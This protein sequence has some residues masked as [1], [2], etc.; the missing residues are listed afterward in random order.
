ME[1]LVERFRTFIHQHW[2]APLNYHTCIPRETR[3]LVRDLLRE[4]IRQA[5][6]ISGN[7]PSGRP[8]NLFLKTYVEQNPVYKEL[9]KNNV[10]LL[11]GAQAIREF[12]DI[13]TLGRFLL[14]VVYRI[15]TGG[16]GKNE[17]IMDKYDQTASKEVVDAQMD[18]FCY[19][20]MWHMGSLSVFYKNKSLVFG[21]PMYWWRKEQN[22]NTVSTELEN[23]FQRYDPKN[24][25]NGAK[26]FVK[27]MVDT[28][29]KVGENIPP[30][31]NVSFSVFNT[32]FISS[33][34][35]FIMDG[36][37]YTVWDKITKYGVTFNV[38]IFLTQ[39]RYNG[40]L[41]KTVEHYKQGVIGGISK[42]DTIDCSAIR[43]AYIPS[44]SDRRKAVRSG[45][46][47]RPYKLENLFVNQHNVDDKTPEIFTQNH[48]NNGYYIDY[49]HYSSIEQITN[50]EFER[51]D[52]LTYNACRKHR[53]AG[54]V[55]NDKTTYRR[56]LRDRFM[57]YLDIQPDPPLEDGTVGEDPVCM[58][59]D[60]LDS[61]LKPLEEAIRSDPK[62][63]CPAKPVGV[64]GSEGTS[65]VDYSGAIVREINRPWST[66]RRSWLTRPL[67]RH[68]PY[69]YPLDSTWWR[70][71]DG[72]I[73]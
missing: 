12:D 29:D 4:Y 42:P 52:R 2:T 36:L 69:R 18:Y 56:M 64:S 5:P 43:F 26:S 27:Y 49:Q 6:P 73:W 53:F 40:A 33:V 3:K 11:E 28:Y 9:F 32:D 44:L 54:D 25:S 60:K 24:Y 1:A 58:D 21:I 51:R 7:N 10:W 16:M 59:L 8:L 48:Y 50:N 62:P 57:G 67:L 15:M 14:M 47:M 23:Y 68:H 35:E 37:C 71:R 72:A 38:D 55:D 34:P 39:N 63:C 30:H 46:R 20:F 41:F 17:T 45:V 66:A 19:N 13:N 65:S 61:L 22:V 70:G 31:V